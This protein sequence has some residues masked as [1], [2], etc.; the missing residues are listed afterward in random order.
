MPLDVG[1][2]PGAAAR[3]PR[4]GRGAD[5]RRRAA[6]AGGGLR[7]PG[8]LR[9]ARP[10]HALGRRRGGLP[11]G[12][13]GRLRPP[14]PVGARRAARSTTSGA[15]APSPSR[16]TASRC[17]STPTRR[18]RPRRWRRLEGATERPTAAYAAVCASQ[19][20]PQTLRGAGPG[21]RERRAARGHELR[22]RDRQPGRGLGRPRPGARARPG[23]RPAT[24]CWR[25]ATAPA[26]RSPRTS[27]S[28]PTRPRA[29]PRPRSPGEA[30]DL[31]TY[32]RW[33]RGRQAEPH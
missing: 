31:S 18:R 9:R 14:G 4:A 1:G 25:S 19:P 7:P 13:V 12:G 10:R 33:T 24:T 15:W 3:R 20:H 27:R 17:S 11:G 28:P 8:Q 30:I 26:R 22:G 2:H 16:A 29:A 21:R 6:G 23:R 32:Y 5:R